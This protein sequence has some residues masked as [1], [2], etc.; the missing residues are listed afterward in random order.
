MPRQSLGWRGTIALVLCGPRR[1][2]QAEGFKK[3]TRPPG[4]RDWVQGEVIGKCR[5]Q[6]ISTGI[7]YSLPTSF[8]IFSGWCWV[9]ETKG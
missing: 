3:P 1:L 2:L 8:V 6:P 7:V 5:I 9:S 4:G